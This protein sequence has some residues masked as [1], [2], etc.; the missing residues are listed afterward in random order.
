MRGSQGMDE[1]EQQ[2]LREKY[3]SLL[4]EFGKL[5][6]D[7]EQ[8]ER[9]TR[10]ML[11]KLSLAVDKAYPELEEPVRSLRE[12]VRAAE[13]GKLPWRVLTAGVSE[14][15]ESIRVVEANA[16]IES[17]QDSLPSAMEP[18][19]AER[20]RQ[21]RQLLSVMLERIA[22]TEELEKRRSRLIEQLASESDNTVTS[23]LI[24]RAAMLVNDMRRQ[25]E[26]EKNDLAS[27]LKQV[28]HTLGDIDRHAA[29]EQDR[30]SS[31]RDAS[32]ALDE[33]VN[34]QV[35]DIGAE[36][37]QAT[38]LS[39]L[40][41][42]VQERL[43]RICKHVAEYRQAD[44]KRVAEAEAENQKLRTHVRHL[45][46]ETASLKTSLDESRERLLRDTLTGLP[47]R[48]AFEERV[49]LELARRKREHTPLCLAIWDIDL[50]KQ[51]NDNFGHKAGDK[52]LY[53]VGRRLAKLV[54]E[55]DMVARFGGEEFVML[56][57]K[58]SLEH[59]LPVVDRMRE[60]IAN[61]PF[62]FKTDPIRITLSCGITE[63][64]QGEGIEDTFER[65]DSALY[66]A[67]SEGRNR[68]VG[69]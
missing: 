66:R 22:F 4:D 39:T 5:E 17:E 24:D 28:T 48:L 18:S 14:I 26:S 45:E 20:N 68:C 6:G 53:V 38:E 62:R 36:V 64:R 11:G 51:V 19:V 3:Q 29:T 52:A 65:A 50:F 21:T 7:L 40:K 1:R 43:G 2:A 61:T 25:V 69:A 44:Q 59:A 54:R 42:A 49:R 12:Q 60:E 35:A 55:V 27:F 63:H 47:N 15:I 31:Q 13:E 58:T 9:L 56:L 8:A 57:P 10:Q 32:S 46:H 30:L 16:A 37:D 34:R 67:K 41:S 33:A 23:V